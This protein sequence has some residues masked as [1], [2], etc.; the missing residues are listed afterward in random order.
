MLYFDAIVT[1]PLFH[2]FEVSVTAET[3]QESKVIKFGYFALFFVG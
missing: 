1:K 3:C 2:P